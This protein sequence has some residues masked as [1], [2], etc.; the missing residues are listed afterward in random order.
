MDIHFLAEDAMFTSCG[1]STAGRDSVA[2]TQKP[3]DVTCI[4]CKIMR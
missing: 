2:V 3:R 4:V 1:L